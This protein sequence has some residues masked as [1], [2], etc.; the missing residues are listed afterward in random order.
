MKK[1]EH[2]EDLRILK[3][4]FILEEDMIIIDSLIQNLLNNKTLRTIS[5][6]DSKLTGIKL[7]KS[8]H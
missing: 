5:R 1:I 3:N 8:S 4:Q 6:L 2:G 7:F